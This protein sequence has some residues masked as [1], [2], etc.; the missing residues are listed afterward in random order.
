MCAD[1]GDIT[2]M[3]KILIIGTI[4]CL[5]YGNIVMGACSINSLG[6]C[7]AEIKRQDFGNT[8]IQDRI[9]PSRINNLEQPN[10]VIP[11]RN[12]QGQPQNPPRMNRE[13]LQ[14]ESTQP[15]NSNCQFGN[16]I[17]RTNAGINNN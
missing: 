12:Q 8:S 13:L 6:V 9:I 7:Q 5:G 15:Y 1:I 16:C 11:N 3:R 4:L 10:T 17:N 2:I 14:Q